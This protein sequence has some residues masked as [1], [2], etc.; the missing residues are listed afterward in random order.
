MLNRLLD[1]LCTIRLHLSWLIYSELFIG[2]ILI[3]RVFLIWS[4][5]LKRG[6][7]CYTDK[8]IFCRENL[9]FGS[10]KFLWFFVLFCW[11][12]T[13]RRKQ[14]CGLNLN[15]G[16]V[17]ISSE[18]YGLSLY[19]YRSGVVDFRCLKF[20]LWRC[21]KAVVDESKR[22]L[23][24]QNWLWSLSINLFV[25]TSLN[26]CWL[27]MLPNHKFLIRV[28]IVLQIYAPIQINFVCCCCR[29]RCR[30]LKSRFSSLI[31]TRAAP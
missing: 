29:R 14:F 31:L 28:F 16:D 6:L 23:L 17:A 22:L 8:P 18:H 10:D 12:W 11:E 5:H 2:F 4:I 26:I 20:A 21:L 25:R 9:I 3:E 27:A 30:I 1:G 7:F 15:L 24:Y 19:Y 13:S